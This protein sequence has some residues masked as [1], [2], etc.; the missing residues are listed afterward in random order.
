MSVRN[1]AR[2]ILVPAADVYCRSLTVDIAQLHTLATSVYCSV[3][4]FNFLR[5][6]QQLWSCIYL[7]SPFT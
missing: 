2:V 5:S 1:P 6:S 3:G 4:W 7:D